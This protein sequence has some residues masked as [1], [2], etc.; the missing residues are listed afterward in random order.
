M[1]GERES[2]QIQADLSNLKE[3]VSEIKEYLGNGIKRHTEVMS[4]I[5]VIT[6]NQANFQA[7][8]TLVQTNLATYQKNCDD[9]R[10]GLGGRLNDV[11]N[12]QKTQIKAA[13]AAGGFVGFLAYGGGKMLEKIGA[14]F[15]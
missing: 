12:F 4:A 14:W 7:N 9:D 15:S 11:E 13:A 3:S 2:G 6:S 8:L 10:K 5:A 1:P